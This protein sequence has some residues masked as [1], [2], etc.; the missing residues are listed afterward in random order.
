LAEKL[1]MIIEIDYVS[2]KAIE[3]N[4]YRIRQKLAN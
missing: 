1:F 4:R 2:A 3:M